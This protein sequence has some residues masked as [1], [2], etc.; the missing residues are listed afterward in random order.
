MGGPLVRSDATATGW[1]GA[2]VEFWR[3]HT[4]SNTYES[5]LPPARL[6]H[7]PPRGSGSFASCVPRVACWLEIE[8]NPTISSSIEQTVSHNQRLCPPTPTP[9]ATMKVFSVLV[10]SA[11]LSFGCCQA[12]DSDYVYGRDPKKDA[13]YDIATGMAGIQQAAKD[14]KLLAQLMQDMQVRR[15]P[16]ATTN[17]EH[18]LASSRV[19]CPAPIHRGRI[20]STFQFD[21][22]QRYPSHDHRTP[23]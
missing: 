20:S 5:Y 14:P 11:L 15:P 1:L 22:T 21:S 9:R 13:E 23:N 4:S 17:L 18:R 16:R 19:H 3:V 7:C 8:I 10:S 12:A 2:Q 6:I